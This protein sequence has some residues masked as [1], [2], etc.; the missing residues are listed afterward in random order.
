MLHWCCFEEEVSFP[1]L[2][3][4][5]SE[6]TQIS[7][8]ESSEKVESSVLLLPDDDDDWLIE[9]KYGDNVFSL[10]DGESMT[11]DVRESLNPSL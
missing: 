5:S 8:L 1:L 9:S 10:V 3:S 2:S 11:S 7:V 6:D 4:S